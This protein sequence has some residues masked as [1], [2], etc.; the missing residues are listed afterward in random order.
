[1][2]AAQAAEKP[3]SILV[4]PLQVTGA[5]GHAGGSERTGGGLATFRPSPKSSGFYSIPAKIQVMHIIYGG[6]RWSP[7]IHSQGWCTHSSIIVFWICILSSASLWLMLEEGTRL[8]CCIDVWFS[9]WAC[10]CIFRDATKKDSEMQ[11]SSRS[12]RAWKRKAN[13]NTGQET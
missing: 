1:M 11:T 13:H 12:S 5:R 9:P 8:I 2:L 3:N 10:A 6:P 7:E 4:V